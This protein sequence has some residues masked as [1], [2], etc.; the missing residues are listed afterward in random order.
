[1][2]LKKTYLSVFFSA[3]T[4]RFRVVLDTLVSIPKYISLK[5]LQNIPK[6]K[7]LLCRKVYK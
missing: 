1:M 7:V 2:F 6:I 5:Q 3:L 4:C